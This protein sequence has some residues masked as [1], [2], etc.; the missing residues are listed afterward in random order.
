MKYRS[1][2]RLAGGSRDAV[3]IFCR[4]AASDASSGRAQ[5]L[6]QDFAERIFRQRVDELDPLGTL[7]TR[8]PRTAEILELSLGYRRALAQADES[9]DDLPPFDRRDADNGAFIDGGMAHENG[10]DFGGRDIFA[11]ADYHVVLAAGE[12]NVAVVVEPSEVAGRAPSVGQTRVVVA[13]GVTLHD[14]RGADDYFADLAV[15]EKLAVFVANANLDV[16]QRLADR[17]EALELELDLRGRAFDSMIFG[18]EHGERR[19]GFGLPVGVHEADFFRKDLD[20]AAN[21]L[22]RHRR[23]AVGKIG[24]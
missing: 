9:L 14:A 11:A 17:V 8:Q 1:R 15:R 7:E 21:D 6:A 16:G 4:R 5:I 18:P 22:H 24:E 19:G 23:A 3:G 13:A 20:R 10:F 2:R 12:E